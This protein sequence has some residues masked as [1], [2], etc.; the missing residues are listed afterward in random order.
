M[1]GCI[2][3]AAYYLFAYKL[4]YHQRSQFILNFFTVVAIIFVLGIIY[5]L[6][7]T[8]TISIPATGD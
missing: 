4:T 1:L 7:T 3:P 5:E 6:V 2:L 8:G